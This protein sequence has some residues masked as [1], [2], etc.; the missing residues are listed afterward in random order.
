MIVYIAG[1]MTGMPGKGRKAFREAEKQLNKQGHVVLN[2]ARLP[3][4]LRSGSYMPICL[5]M[6]Q[7]ADAVYLLDNWEDSPG[8][9]LECQ[10]AQYQGKLVLLGGQFGGETK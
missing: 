5:A 10:Y 4:G 2:P 7:Q 3:D 1:K 6:L 8:A 9:K